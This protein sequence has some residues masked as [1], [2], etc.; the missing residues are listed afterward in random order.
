MGEAGIVTAEGKIIKLQVKQFPLAVWTVNSKTL[1]KGDFIYWKFWL[2]LKAVDYDA[3][4]LKVR[5]TLSQK[6]QFPDGTVL[7]DWVAGTEQ[8]ASK[9]GIPLTAPDEE[10]FRVDL[11][12]DQVVIVPIKYR[13]ATV[14]TWNEPD[15]TIA[16][17]SYYDGKSMVRSARIDR[18][19]PDW[20]DWEDGTYIWTVR[21]T[22]HE[23]V[24]EQTGE[25]KSMTP[26]PSTVE[27]TFT[28]KKQSGSLEAT[29]SSLASH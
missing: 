25:V 6:L 24:W 29:L 22:V 5:F 7:T 11:P 17:F 28:I 27:Y 8:V 4:L 26:K 1:Q 21:C 12:K 3:K 19:N 23:I 9:Y 15:A 10:W 13:D 2:N 14:P 16:P 20:N 18:P